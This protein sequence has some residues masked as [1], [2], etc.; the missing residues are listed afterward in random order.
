MAN[1]FVFSQ[2]LC[3]GPGSDPL[4]C[5]KNKGKHGF[6]GPPAPER[7]EARIEKMAKGQNEFAAHASKLKLAWPGLNA[8]Q[9]N[10]T[11]SALT[12]STDIART[13]LAGTQLG[14]DAVG[15]GRSWRDAV[16]RDVAG[17][18]Q[19]ARDVAG[20]TQLGGTTQLA[21][22]VAGGTQLGGTQL[23]RFDNAK[24]FKQKFSPEVPSAPVEALSKWKRQISAQS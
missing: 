23:T 19:L 9:L 4:E 18:T 5:E 15:T 11:N 22:D 3:C 7:L 21:R 1:R 10:A 16:R 13:Q 12:A 17:G 24:D 6:E 20:R 2:V 14:W 8:R